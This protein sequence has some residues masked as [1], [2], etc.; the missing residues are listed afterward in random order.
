MDTTMALNFVTGVA[1]RD[2]DAALTAQMAAVLDSDPKAQILLLV[3]NHIKFDSE[4]AVLRALRAHTAAD[5]PLYAQSRVQIMS[6]SRLAWFFLKDEALFQLPRLSPAAMAMRLT[7]IMTEAKD[8]LHLFASQVTNAGFAARLQRQLSELQMGRVTASDLTAAIATLEATGKGTQQ[9]PKLRD[10]AR[11][12]RQFEEEA[13]DSIGAADLMTAL[14]AKLGQSDLSHTHVFL[15]HFNVLAAQELAI[16]QI[17]MTRAA[18]VTVTLITDATPNPRQRVTGVLG[19]L[20]GLYV[21]AQN[22]QAR[23]LASAKSAHVAV[24][25][26]TIAPER[27]LSATMHNVER[28]FQFYADAKVTPESALIRHDDKLPNFDHLTLARAQTPYTEL[29]TVAREIRQ[30]IQ[31]GARYRDFLIMA[32]RLGPYATFAPAVFREFNL[33]YFIDHERQMS[34]HPLIVLIDGLMAIM[35][36][37]YDYQGVFGLLRTELLVPKEMTI[38]DF[39][40]AVDTTENH[41]LATGVRGKR[42]LDPTPWTYYTL[43]S[44]DA[45]RLAAAQDDVRSVQINQIKQ[46]VAGTI[47]PFLE[48]LQAATTG[49]EFAAILYTFC[50]DAGVKDQLTHWRD[51]AEAAGDITGAQGSEQAWQVFCDLLDDLAG[52]WGDATLDLV[53]LTEMLD[54][55]FASAT[56]TQIPGTLDQV[57][58]SETGLVRRGHVRHVYLI[59]ATATALPEAASDNELLNQGDR[60]ALAGVLPDGCFL[61]DTG[62]DGA[63]GEPFLNYLALMASN[64]TLTMSYPQR[65]LDGENAASLYLDALAQVSKKQWTVWQTPQDGDAAQPYLGTRRS[66]LSD[67]L[68]IL[69]RVRDGQR[70][71]LSDLITTSGTDWAQVIRS[72]RQ[73][74][75]HVLA[76]RLF[77]SLDDTNASGRLQP[78]IARALYGDHLDVSVSRL[79]TYYKNPFE[80][81]LKYG[82]ALQPRREFT[83]TPAD[84]GLLFHS[85]MAAL[86]ASDDGTSALTTLDDAQLKTVVRDLLKQE[87]TRPEFA[88]L[89]SSA[90]MTY[91]THL[92]EKMARRSAWAVRNQQQ[93]SGFTT[94]RPEVSFGMG[95]Q[96]SLPPILLH[97]QDD[98]TIRIRGR[99]DRLDTHPTSNGT[100]FMVVDYKSGDRRFEPFKSYYGLSIQMLTYLEAVIRAGLA[101]NEKMIPTAGVY[102]HLQDP[103]L[104]Y[105]PVQTTDQLI[106]SITKKMK[107]QGLL[108]ETPAIDDLEPGLFAGD[109]GFTPSAKPADFNLIITGKGRPRVGSLIVT[110]ADLQLLLDNNDQ[111][112]ARA[113]AD[114]LAGVIDLTPRRFDRK[115]DVINQSDYSPIMQFDP[116]MAGNQYEQLTK[117][118]LSEV[119]DRLRQNI[120][121]YETPEKGG[122]D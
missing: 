76:N 63:L 92:V 38:Q 98:Q 107:L 24:G 28:F 48:R 113:A 89:S 72:L 23:L 54:A 32:R 90:R 80:Y 88:I 108:V 110:L 101:R 116:T 7:K 60:N 47:A 12:M 41:V 1:S 85:I 46:L 17:L 79:E 26:S 115:A 118:G 44:D 36:S 75:L 11:I 119:L 74:P 57:Q 2:H 5:A 106:P 121:P 87:A 95:G 29:R 68:I 31:A 82:L 14:A 69:R 8:E 114:I 43:Y 65:S 45:D 67:A 40:N 18:D 20:P 15:S 58:L 93:R 30:K 35:R 34:T 53:Q 33:P 59:G 117:Y 122:M 97:A 70:L 104:D 78:T 51:D 105:E 10:L 9:L 37:H 21:P 112:I 22:M 84:T 13:S 109:T 81:F 3:P 4:V 100:A 56:Y 50:V 52:T 102:L 64:E 99:I 73:G 55:G 6:F 111:L 42:W 49:R 91:I 96:D 83:L 103:R 86:V 62:S 16:T 61:P 19:Q 66:T 27:P 94:S 25:H 120:R 77:A 39:R 71:A